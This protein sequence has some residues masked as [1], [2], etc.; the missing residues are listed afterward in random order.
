MPGIADAVLIQPVP[1]EVKFVGQGFQIGDFPGICSRFFQQFLQFF[2]HHPSLAFVFRYGPP[3]LT[4][5]H[6]L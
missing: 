2:K 3:S 6:S 5:T 1:D 4:L